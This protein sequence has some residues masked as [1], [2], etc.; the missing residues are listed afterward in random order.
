M[1]PLDNSPGFAGNGGHCILPHRWLSKLIDKL[2]D[3]NLLLRGLRI[4]KGVLYV[5]EILSQPVVSGWDL[6][7]VARTW[8]RK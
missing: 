6:I 5:K 4:P 1:I 8:V 7:P 3:K 2:I